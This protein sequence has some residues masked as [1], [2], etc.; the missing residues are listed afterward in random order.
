MASCLATVLP[1]VTWPSPPRATCPS[2]RTLRI[3]VDR[4]ALVDG[5][6]HGIAYSRRGRKTHVIHSLPLLLICAAIAAGRSVHRASAPAGLAAPD[7]AA[8]GRRREPAVRGGGGRA[9]AAAAAA[10]VT[11]VLVDLS[12]STRTARFSHPQTTSPRI[13]QLHRETSIPHRI[14]R[15]WPRGRAAKCRCAGRRDRRI[16]RFC[17]SDIAAEPILLFS[18]ARFALPAAGPPMYPVVDPALEDSRRCVCAVDWR[19]QGRQHRSRSA[20]PAHL[21]C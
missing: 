15:R 7:A 11:V 13:G 20:M 12:P 2:R 4:A 21:A 5:M 6:E 8:G 14:F 17:R 3:V 16:G 9:V 1:S 10:R 19:L 18:D